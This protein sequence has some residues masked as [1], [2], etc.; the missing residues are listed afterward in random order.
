M[1]CRSWA[2]LHA[3]ARATR[4]SNAGKFASAQVGDYWRG[5]ATPNNGDKR[6][7][8]SEAYGSR[9]QI[10]AKR[11]ARKPP[12]QPNKASSTD[13]RQPDLR[14]IV[15]ATTL[16]SLARESLVASLARRQA[17]A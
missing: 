3:E 1:S 17:S 6:I 2:Q 10:N 9:L 11:A 5:T 14:A 16:Q 4:G 13:E 12:F 15:A 8:D 7:R